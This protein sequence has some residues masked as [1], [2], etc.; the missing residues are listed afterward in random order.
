MSETE[1]RSGKSVR[2]LKFYF[3]VLLVFVLLIALSFSIAIYYVYHR[4]ATDSRL[5]QMVMEKASSA[6]QMDVKFASLAV[7]FPGVEIKD[8]VLATETPNL[9]VNS[10]IALV[11]V[12]PDFWAALEGNFVL[13]YLS[14]S[15]AS[16]IIEMAAKTAQVSAEEPDK[17][18]G[19]PV[20]LTDVK[21]PFNTLDLNAVRFKIS[22]R[23]AGVANDVVLNNATLARSMLTT[24]MPFSLDAE[25]PDKADLR[26]NGKLHWPVKVVADADFKFQNISELKKMLP[27]AYQKKIEFVESIDGKVAFEYAIDKGSL[28]LNPCRVNVQPGLQCNGEVTIDK[29]SPLN[30]SASFKIAPIAM[31]TLWPLVRDFIPKEHGILISKGSVSGAVDI[32]IR[33]GKS[34]S[35]VVTLVPENMQIAAKAVET[36]IQLT[37]GQLNYTNGKIKLSGFESRMADM[38]LKMSS[39]AITLDPVTFAGDLAAD[40]DADTIWKLARPFL[41]ADAA[42]VEPSGKLA[43]SG[44][45]AYAGKGVSLDGVLDSEQLKFR[46]AKTSAQVTLDKIRVKFKDFGPQKGVVNFERCELNGVGAAVKFSGLLTNAVDM[47]FDL[48]A[49]GDLNVDE[50]S[51]LGGVLFKLPVREGQ[52]KGLI[53]MDVKLGG[54]LKNL[55]PQGRVGFKNVFADLSERG[56]VVAKLNGGASADINTLTLEKLSA[57]LLGGTIAITGSLNDFKK[58]VVDAKASISGADLVSIRTLIKK[59]YPDMP[60][61]IEFG[62]KADLTVNLTGKIAEPNLKGEALLKSVRFAHPAVLRPIENINGPVSFTNAGLVAKG[63]RAEWGT[64]VAT[65]DG[66]LKDWAKF[67][68]DFKFK[69]DPLDMTDAAGFFLK[70]TGYVAQ[71]KGTGTGSITGPVEKIKV[72]GNASVPSGLF[73]APVSAKGD[74]FKFP[75]KNLNARAVYFNRVLDVTSADMELFSGKVNAAGKV[76]IASE[77][78]RF[79]FDA[80]IKNLMTQ[81]FLKENTSYKNVLQGGLDGTFAAKGNT[82]GLATLNGNASLAMP[83]GSY[84]SPPVMRQI[85]ENLSAAHLASGTIENVAGDYIISGGRISSKNTVAKSKDG[86]VVF[87]GSVGL[88]ATLDGEAQFQIKRESCQQSKILRD[89]VGNNEF[90]DVPISLKGSIMSPAVGIPLDRMLKET[91]ERKLKE[92]LQKEAGKALGKLFGVK[93]QPAST[94]SSTPVASPADLSVETAKPVPTVASSPAEPTPPKKIEDKIK[95][96]GKELKGLKNIF[97]F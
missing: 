82:L 36:P 96:I 79:E 69:V 25:L 83:K 16:T 35:L 94:A 26:I 6:L 50:F 37:R 14:I 64:S 19:V 53:S 57:E 93:S 56:L 61:E 11:K 7:V 28:K 48:S 49:S 34:E 12:R 92:G 46:D 17:A 44:N 52:F 10:E 27:V 29:F 5:E 55:K 85:V 75:F 74:L 33:G 65:V 58:P 45:L 76:F 21:F 30:A 90:L 3:K 71:G 70:D 32:G 60:D 87:T 2:G 77:P 22:D 67:V 95:D 20:D 4:F 86:K 80:K 63:V 15:S 72:E 23:N 1:N 13:D 31:D 38:F 91:A 8:V 81:E 51:R 43:F 73:A 54:T 84:N 88:D 59:N 78:F 89:L 24:S 47:G 97:K 9:K 41:S 39:A 18:D 40:L 42:Q 66:Q 62:G 68:T